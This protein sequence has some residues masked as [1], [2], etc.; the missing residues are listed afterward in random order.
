MNGNEVRS[1]RYFTAI[2]KV[3]GLRYL[4]SNKGYKQVDINGHVVSQ[5]DVEVT[6]NPESLT[7]YL[8]KMLFGSK[9]ISSLPRD[10]KDSC[11]L[12]SIHGKDDLKVKFY[13]R[14]MYIFKDYLHKHGWNKYDDYSLIKYPLLNNEHDLKALQLLIS[15]ESKLDHEAFKEN[16]LNRV[17][18]GTS[19][20][21]R[22]SSTEHRL[23][24]WIPLYR[25]DKLDS[26]ISV[27]MEI[28]S[29]MF[30]D[31]GDDEEPIFSTNI[32]G[33][34]DGI[35]DSLSLQDAGRTS[36]FNYKDLSDEIL[37][38]YRKRSRENQDLKTY[39]GL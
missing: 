39:L 5:Y 31:I 26:F 8:N 11:F 6:G 32:S 25:F 14:I 18:V 15:L 30:L 12:A 34:R 21:S 19:Q 36:I 4:L 20:D 23:T 38:K 7:L 37:E 22:L 2:R 1:E 9:V 27:E 28:T 33:H 3:S 10:V 16:R 24:L 35:S 29:I 13:D 17:Y